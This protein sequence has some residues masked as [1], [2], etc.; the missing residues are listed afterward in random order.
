MGR[1][2]RCP[3]QLHL[4]T[5]RA[6]RQLGSSSCM[7]PNSL[8]AISAPKGG[9]TPLNRSGTWCRG[10][11]LKQ[12]RP[13]GSPSCKATSRARA[14]EHQ[15]VGTA[16][17]SA[18]ER[19]AG[20]EQGVRLLPAYFCQAERTAHCLGAL[21]TSYNHQA[22]PRPCHPALPHCTRRA[23]SQG[24]RL[25]P[26]RLARPSLR[27]G[28]GEGEGGG[29][30]SGEGKPRSFLCAWSTSQSPEAPCNPHPTRDLSLS[31]GISLSH[32]PKCQSPSP[33]LSV[34]AP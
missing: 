27:G 16:I 8:G 7:P 5:C 3:V 9:E 23:W 13:E 34:S 19:T 15:A 2:S 32:P 4:C 33:A 20:S 29:G 14:T 24:H 11:L 26:G 31:F 6:L 12:A 1:A 30:W 21:A 17:I 28:G 10:S 22:P 25:L 18:E